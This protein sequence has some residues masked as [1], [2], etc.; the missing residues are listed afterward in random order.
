MVKCPICGVEFDKNKTSCYTAKRRYIHEECLEQYKLKY[1]KNEVTKYIPPQKPTKSKPK[2]QKNIKICRWCNGPVDLDKDEYVLLYN[3]KRYAHKSCHEKAT[4]GDEHF[5]DLIYEYLGHEV[6]IKYDY[7]NCE[8]QRKSYLK[9]MKYTNEG[10]Y[11]S[12]KYFYGVQKGSPEKSGNRIG[13]VPYI[14]TEANEYFQKL[15]QHK[16]EINRTMG[17]QLN[18]EAKQISF[19]KQITIQD[20]G[21]IDIDNI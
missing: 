11:N 4:A 10:I 8:R 7:T 6:G 9:T 2:T 17:E 19:K 3:G 15:E 16:R 13:I 20:R 1:P 18:T 21:F 12:L 5:I 14:Y